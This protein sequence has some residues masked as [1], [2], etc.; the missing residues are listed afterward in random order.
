MQFRTAISHAFTA[1]M[2]A[3]LVG[4]GSS[5]SAPGTM[6]V[7]LVDGPEVDYTA[8]NLQIKKL[9]IHGPNGWETLADFTTTQKGVLELD[10]LTLRG[11]DGNGVPIKA[12]LT[13]HKAL[14]EGH[15]DQMRML[16]GPDNT[17]TLSAAAGGGTFPL[18]VPSGMQSGLKFPVSFDV[19]PNTT[20]DV[21]IDMDAHRS[22]FLHQTG[23]SAPK[24]LLRPVIH[25]VDRLVTGYVT[26]TLTAAVGGAG[27]P[28]VDVF[29]E[30]FDANGRPIIVTHALTDSAGKYVLDYL[31]VGG[32]YHVVAQ[33]VVT[34]T[35]TPVVT[36]VYLPKA[37]GP[38]AISE[39]Q[40]TVTYS[41]S[42]DAT[43][44][45]GSVSGAITNVADLDQTDTVFVLATIDAK[46]FVVRTSPAPVNRSVTP[47]T[48]G[49][50]IANLPL[51]DG[52][53]LLAVER[54]TDDG[55][56]GTTFTWK[57]DGGPAILGTSATAP[58]AL[59]NHDLT[60]Q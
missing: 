14:P 20:R 13:D 38:F 12:T 18:K 37:S 24:Y 7:H 26:G 46:P 59:T 34:G 52:G 31:P 54:G 48:E 60:A 2:F 35:A 10:L 49:Y 22:I 51:Y 41:A 36:T 42:F 3:V 32:S 40:P 39:T 45:V 47:P 19:A 43:A 16:L 1:V 56:G 30:T 9:E 6:S 29:A 21:F 50:S 4:C 25:A 27:L 28:N 17:V 23:G 44:A 8:V 11:L 57:M 5:A 58:F 33:P 53:Y 15:Y 55:S